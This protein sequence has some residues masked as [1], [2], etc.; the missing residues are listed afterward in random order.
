MEL[1][2]Q[3]LELVVVDLVVVRA[4]I[5]DTAIRRRR[6][7]GGGTAGVERIEQF[8]E[9]GVAELGRGVVA[10]SRRRVGFRRIVGRR[11]I[12]FAGRIVLR[13]G[14]S[15]GRYRSCLPGVRRAARLHREQ[16]VD[17]FRRRR[18]RLLAGANLREHV[19]DFVEHAQE[20][21]H[22]LRVEHEF[23]IT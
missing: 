21:I 7:L 5:D 11:R 14:G 3:R 22:H 13:R 6:G 9:F 15:V 18:L 20:G 17:Q 19:I 8:G 1:I 16:F 2:E 23:T 10:V 12:D 4:G